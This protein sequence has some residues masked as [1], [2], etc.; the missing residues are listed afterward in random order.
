[1][2][3]TPITVLTSYRS[4]LFHSTASYLFIFQYVF[5][6]LYMSIAWF[7][8]CTIFNE[9]KYNNS[10]NLFYCTR[11]FKSTTNGDDGAKRTTVYM[12]HILIITFQAKFCWGEIFEYLAWIWT[13]GLLNVGRVTR[14]LLYS[15]QASLLRLFRLLHRRWDNLMGFLAVRKI[16]Q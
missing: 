1:M 8:I 12:I 13:C 14:R 15:V 3:K 9:Y 16:E 11:Y 5:K 10:N 7:F 2:Y 6:C 4:I